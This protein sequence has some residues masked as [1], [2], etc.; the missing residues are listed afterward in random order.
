MKYCILEMFSS[1][2]MKVKII[3]EELANK[4]PLTPEAKGPGIKQFIYLVTLPLFVLLSYFLSSKALGLFIYNI[5][6]IIAPTC[7]NQNMCHNK[8]PQ[9]PSDLK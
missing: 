9:D 7:I 6:I 4:F 5:G 8:Q 1:V 2:I 3:F